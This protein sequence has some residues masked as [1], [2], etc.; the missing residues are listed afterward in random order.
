MS[1]SFLC[2]FFWNS[3]LTT[4][5]QKKT[6]S[7]LLGHWLVLLYIIVSNCIQ[8]VAKNR[9]SFIHFLFI[10]FLSLTSTFVIE[11]WAHQDDLPIS[12]ILINVSKS[13]PYK[14]HLW[15]PRIST[16]H[17]WWQLFSL[18]T[19]LKMKLNKMIP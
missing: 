7:R 4:P 9:I 19:S 10:P 14:W 17:L 15:V 16:H 5:Y 8:F 13:F 3:I 11:F 12:I 1:V 2:R 6:N 18:P